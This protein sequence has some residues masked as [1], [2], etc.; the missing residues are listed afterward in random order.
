MKAKKV[1]AVALTAAMT[2]INGSI[3]ERIRSGR[4]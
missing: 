3:C 2:V 1:A 4:I